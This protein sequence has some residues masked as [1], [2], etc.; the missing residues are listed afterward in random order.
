MD[1]ANDYLSFTRSHMLMEEVLFFPAVRKTLTPEDWAE[2]DKAWE[3]V[4]DPL[5]GEQTQKKYEGLYQEIMN[6]E[7]RSQPQVQASR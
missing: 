2:L 5:F 3:T 4:E 1:V 7:D 6:W